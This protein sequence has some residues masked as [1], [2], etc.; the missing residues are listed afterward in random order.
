MRFHDKSACKH[1]FIIVDNKKLILQSQ[2][3]V[4]LNPKHGDLYGDIAFI[5]DPDIVHQYVESFKWL[6]ESHKDKAHVLVA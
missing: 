6:W 5:N 1:N 2:G 4:P 3:W